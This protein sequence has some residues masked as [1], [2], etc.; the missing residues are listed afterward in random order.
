MSPIN[1][2]LVAIT[3][4]GLAAITISGCS[5]S[6]VSSNPRNVVVESQSLNAGDAQRLADAECSKHNRF[7]KMTI[8]GDYWDRN[9]TFE[10]VE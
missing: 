2:T 10:C 1:A 4:T 9:Y 7:A 6:V 8:K 3:L 5:A